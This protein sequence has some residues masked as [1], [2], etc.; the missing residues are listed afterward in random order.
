MSSLGTLVRGRNWVQGP[1]WA[2]A[3]VGEGRRCCTEMVAQPGGRLDAEEEDGL[4]MP[5]V[6]RKPGVLG[7][8]RLWVGQV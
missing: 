4:E 8:P 3:L 6:D 7:T 5:S 2:A 1:R